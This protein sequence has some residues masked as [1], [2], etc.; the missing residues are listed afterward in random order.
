LKRRE[1]EMKKLLVLT[2]CMVFLLA[3]L[4]NADTLNIGGTYTGMTIWEDGVLTGVGGGSVDPSYLNGTELDYL[5]CVDLYITVNVPGSYPNTVVT[6]D[7][8]IYGVAVHNAGQVAWLLSQ[9]GTAGQGS[10]AY[11]LQAAIWHVV[12]DGI[13]NVFIDNTSSPANVVTL[14]GSYLTALDSNT[15]NI[16]DFRWIT[17]GQLDSNGHVVAYQGLV[18]VP[19]PGILILL[20]IAMSAIGAASW[21]LRKF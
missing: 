9:Y 2:A 19:E 21:R 12:N 5:Y 18:T 11:A 20:G 7:G 13:H 3:G 1:I 17:P 16:S 8:T 10:Q 14:Y 6:T 4:A 15:G